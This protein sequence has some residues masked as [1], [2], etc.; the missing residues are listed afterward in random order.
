M[1]LSEP[2]GL[3]SKGNRSFLA[4]EADPPPHR[5]HA[6]SLSSAPDGR[7]G[8]PC[9]SPSPM[10]AVPVSLKRSTLI[11]TETLLVSG[12]ESPGL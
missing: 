9:V 12:A 5:P 2:A 6:A 1:K 11:Q 8:P 10:E 3:L 7:R 4:G